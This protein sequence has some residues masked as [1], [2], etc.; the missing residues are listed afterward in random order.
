[1]VVGKNSLDNDIEVNICKTKNLTNMRSSGADEALILT[2]PKEITL[3]FALEYI[4][5]DELVGVTPKSI[6]I[7]KKFLN[8]NDRK[9]NK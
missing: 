3:D 4:G 9:R 2:P 6:R 7:R 1:M 8:A 5:N